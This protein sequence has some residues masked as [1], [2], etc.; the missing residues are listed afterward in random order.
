MNGD[1]Q[2]DYVEGVTTVP[3]GTVVY[4][5]NTMLFCIQDNDT[6]TPDIS[7]WAKDLSTWSEIQFQKNVET[8]EK[9]ILSYN[10]CF[11]S[12]S[13]TPLFAYGR[14]VELHRYCGR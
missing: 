2:V 3:N 5:E 4:Y 1:T 6:T 7:V 11:V 12:T 10:F 13:C 9:K 14:M 8:K